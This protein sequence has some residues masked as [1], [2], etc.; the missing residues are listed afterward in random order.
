MLQHASLVLTMAIK[1]ETIGDA[2][3]IQHYIAEFKGPHLCRMVTITNT[4]T[5]PCRTKIQVIWEL[6]AKRTP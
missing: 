6:I 5:A 1:I 3:V 4:I 2:M